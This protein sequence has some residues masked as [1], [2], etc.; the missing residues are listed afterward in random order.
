MAKKSFE[1]YV[2]LLISLI[3][4]NL[5]VKTRLYIQA[6]KW[7]QV[8]LGPDISSL[9]PGMLLLHSRRMVTDAGFE[10]TEEEHIRMVPVSVFLDMPA[11]LYMQSEVSINLIK[12]PKTCCGKRNN[13]HF[14]K[15][16][17]HVK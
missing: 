5:Q 7:N 3:L 16:Y 6:T 2:R 14:V 8:Q 9:L 1:R 13:A 10:E 17:L 12:L 11:L 15:W 4:Y